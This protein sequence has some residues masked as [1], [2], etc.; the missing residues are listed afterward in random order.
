MKINDYIFM[1]FII[2][3]LSYI[4][5]RLATERFFDRYKIE[6]VQYYTMLKIGKE[7]KKQN[8]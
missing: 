1:S 7:F 2:F 5:I 6:I 8:S 3:N 4:R